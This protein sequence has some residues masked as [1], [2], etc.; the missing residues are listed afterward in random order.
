MPV[1]FDHGRGDTARRLHH[2]F[3]GLWAMVGGI[4]IP[5]ADVMY[6][7]IREEQSTRLRLQS[8]VL[9]LSVVMVLT[10]YHP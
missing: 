8:M 10:E 5:C 9:Q 1:G 6:F 7:L 2:I 4:V 3:A